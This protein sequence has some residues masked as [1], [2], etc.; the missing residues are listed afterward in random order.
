M[1]VTAWATAEESDGD[2]TSMEEILEATDCIGDV[3]V[4][5]GDPNLATQNGGY[6]WLVTFLR[7]ADSPC[8][9]VIPIT[10]NVNREY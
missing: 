8:Q 1:T 5:R 4:S 7:D 9:Q 6:A 10:Q 2:G 3:S